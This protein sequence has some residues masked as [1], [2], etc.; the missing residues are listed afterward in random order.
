MMLNVNE[1]SSGHL[2]QTAGSIACGELHITDLKKG[3]LNPHTDI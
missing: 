1:I 2:K 3:S